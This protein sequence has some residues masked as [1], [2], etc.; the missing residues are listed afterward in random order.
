MRFFIIATLGTVIICLL[1]KIHDMKED[2]AAS[3]MNGYITHQTSNKLND[4]INYKQGYITAT[5]D[6][7]QNE[8]NECEA[9]C[10]Q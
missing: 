6:A 5:L 10:T 7:M 1:L 3:W 9:W 8:S 2:A 4:K